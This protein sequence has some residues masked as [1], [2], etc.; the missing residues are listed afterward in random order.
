MTTRIA[1]VLSGIATLIGDPG[2]LSMPSIGE[3][4]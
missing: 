2:G 4:R 1:D 3:V